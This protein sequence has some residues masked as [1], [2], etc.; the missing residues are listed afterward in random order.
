MAKQT[1]RS[2]TSTQRGRSRKRRGITYTGQSSTHDTSGLPGFPA[3]DIFAKP[4]TAFLA[5]EAGRVI[6]LSGS[7]GTSGQIYGYSV[8]FLGK[9]GRLYFI[10]HLGQTRAP[11]GSYKAGAVLGTV[12]AWS[13]GSP[14]AHVGINDSGYNPGSG[15]DSTYSQGAQQQTIPNQQPTQQLQVPNS[16]VSL[17]GSEPP[18]NAPPMPGLPGEVPGLP[19]DDISLEWRK[20][21]SQPLASPE[22]RRWAGLE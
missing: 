4:G 22:T 12:S 1:T 18:P 19:P 14:H 15:D 17:P 10:T 6:R 16:P 21:A 2:S 9:S 8:Y 7:G 5:P 11:I 20:I 13:G 3:V